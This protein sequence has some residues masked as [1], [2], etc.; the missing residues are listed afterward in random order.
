M[1]IDFKPEIHALTQSVQAAVV[2]GYIAAHC[3]AALYRTD[4]HHAR[5]G[6]TPYYRASEKEIAAAIGIHHTAVPRALNNLKSAGLIEDR[7]DLTRK[8]FKPLPYR[9]THCLTLSPLGLTYYPELLP[10]DA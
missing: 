6:Y 1:T 10:P 3:R 5:D 7:K 4:A 8:L 2:M 9:Q